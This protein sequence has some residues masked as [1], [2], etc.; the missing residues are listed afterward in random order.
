MGTL[1]VHPDMPDG[2][3]RAACALEVAKIGTRCTACTLSG[4]HRTLPCNEG[5]MFARDVD[6]G[7]PSPERACQRQF[8]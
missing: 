1:R 3:G 7:K 5:H 6:E 8:D 4:V 2:T